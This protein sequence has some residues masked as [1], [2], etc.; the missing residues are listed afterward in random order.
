VCQLDLIKNCMQPT[1]VR[2]KLKDLPKTLEETYDRI[3][4]TIPEETWQIAR[5]AL[6]LLAY[7]L[8]PL[9]LRELAEAMVVDIK[10]QC[11]DPKE[12]RLNDHRDAL[13]ICS[14]LVTVFKVKNDRSSSWLVEKDEIER[15]HF[16]ST[17]E[18]ET[19]QFAHF[20]VK[21]YVVLQRS[22]AVSP[23]N[24]S[25]TIAHRHIAEISLI[26]L[27][28]FSDGARIDRF[29]FEAFPFLAYAARYWHEHWRL[30]L[31]LDDQASVNALMRRL[32][33]SSKPN[34]YINFLN[35]CNPE[36]LVNR[37]F[38][39]LSLGSSGGKSLDAFPQ[40]LYYTAQLGH[41]EL[42]EW[43]LEDERCDVNSKKG[44]FGQ[45]LQIAAFSGHEKTVKFLL[46]HGADINALGGE[47]GCALQAA[48][49]AGHEQAVR[50]L[51]DHGADVNTLGGRFASALI[52]ACHGGH[53]TTAKVLLD[54]G[55][56]INVIST[57]QGKAL[58]VGAS[59]GNTQLVRLLLQSGADINDTNGGEGSA[60]YAA[61]EKGALDTVKML[62]SAGADVN[63]KSGY[64]CTALQAACSKN[65]IEGTNGNI[66]VAKFLLKSGADCNIRGGE[67]GDTLQ[68]CIEAGNVESN[69][70]L[71]QILLDHGADVD[72]Q[73][74]KYNSAIEAA[75]CTGNIEAAHILLD[76]GVPVDDEIFLLSLR[77]ERTSVIPLL[78]EKGVNVNA[79][80]TRGTALQM[81]IKDN[82]VDTTM[83]LLE[84]PLIDINAKGGGNGE[85]ALYYAV[86]KRNK[87]LVS[88][89]LDR[90]A[91][92]NSDGGYEHCLCVAVM[93]QDEAMVRLLLERG[94]NVNARGK[95]Y[96]GTPLIAAVERENDDLIN[97]LLSHGAN[98]NGRGDGYGEW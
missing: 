69:V 34:S 24:F 79:Q 81:A 74:G 32:F 53:L 85:T 22:K 29:D 83:A 89:L 90:G 7:S 10:D 54:R 28:D 39:R 70:G 19:V 33:E 35:I 45:T 57:H 92:V 88:L 26:Y 78:L 25:D 23:F 77:Y 16:A 55:A 97:L 65:R 87:T 44:T 56:D 18:I 60:L 71:L 43:L 21:E 15:K 3:L 47:Y 38:G 1:S 14:S 67:Y 84:D 66:E 61:A 36:K 2:K 6:L 42:S 86:S 12:H 82:Y 40:P 76:R 68:A 75:V 17:Q 58:N 59:T 11:F 72:Y 5:A 49:F 95:G 48:A 9:T 30:Q 20:S 94:A 80:N 91:D 64:K 8:R 52:A 41:N 37:W 62:V 96:A 4:A 31:C 98:V 27:L 13:E 50:M 46:D 63:L 93:R 73:G 51:L